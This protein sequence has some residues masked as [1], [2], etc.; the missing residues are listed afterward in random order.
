[1]LIWRFARGRLISVNYALRGVP[2]IA[3]PAR[4]QDGCQQTLAC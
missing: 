1:M 2:L 3:A 4:E